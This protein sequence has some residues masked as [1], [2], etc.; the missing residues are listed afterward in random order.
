MT[1]INIGCGKSPTLGWKNYDNSPSL[2]L[3]RYYFLAKT[4]HKLKFINPKQFELIKY[5][6]ENKILWADVRK[7]IPEPDN[8]A[9]VIYSSHMF[10][11]LDKHEA[12]HFLSECHRVLKPDGII[13][14][15]VPN[16][17]IPINEYLKNRDADAFITSLNI[18]V[19]R[20]RTF[21]ETLQFI[22]YGNREHHWMY[23]AKSLSKKLAACGFSNIEIQPAGKTLIAD[24]GNLNLFERED[25]SVYVEARKL[26]NG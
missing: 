13:R 23:D 12:T 9:S 2:K 6:K 26:A 14:I 24:Y 19:D 3:A 7:S 8:S 21:R 15:A 17:E 5:F 18:F 4:L 10:E 22:L 25:E 1:K 16:L 11:H 20:P